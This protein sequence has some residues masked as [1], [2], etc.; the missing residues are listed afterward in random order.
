[1]RSESPDDVFLR[2]GDQPLLSLHLDGGKLSISTKLFDDK[3]AELAELDHNAWTH[4]ARPAIFDRNYTD[5]AFEIRDASGAVTLQVV[6]LGSAIYFAG[7]LHCRNGRATVFGKGARGGTA[8]ELLRPGQKPTLTI[9]PICDYPSTEKLGVCPGI[10]S[11]PVPTSDNP[12]Y[13]F[14]GSIDICGK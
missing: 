7:V 5:N 2:D 13:R 8:W 4:Q 11:L 12:D 9:H 3:G 6:N 14:L 1:M 10:A